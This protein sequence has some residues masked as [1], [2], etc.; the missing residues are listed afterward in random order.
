MQRMEDIKIKKEK[1]LVPV[2]LCLIFVVCC[3]IFLFYLIQKNGRE[4]AAFFS[5]LQNKTRSR[6]RIGWREIYILLRDWQ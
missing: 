1:M 6:L 2:F 5:V 4:D 3:F